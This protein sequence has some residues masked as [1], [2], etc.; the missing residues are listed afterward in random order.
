MPPA[1]RR[2]LI[3]LGVVVGVPVLIGLLF[4]SNWLKGPVERAV[5]ERTGRAFTIGG[6]FDVVPRLP[7]RF[8]MERVRLASPPW[9]AEPETLRL[10]RLEVSLALLPLLRREVVL[11]EVILTQ[12]VI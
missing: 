6:D 5:S 9:A 3:A 11:P 7:P 2:L 10:E 1:R 8:V 4:D 12:P